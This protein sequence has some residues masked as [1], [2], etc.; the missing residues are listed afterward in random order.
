MKKPLVKN[1]ETAIMKKLTKYTLAYPLALAFVSS[2]SLNIQAGSIE[3][4][5]DDKCTD[6]HEK[7]GNSKN[8]H[9]PSIA[10]ISST[11]FIEAMQSYGKDQRPAFKLK[12]EKITMKDVAKKLSKED[13]EKLADYFSKQKFAATKQDFDKALAKKGKKLHKKYCDKCHS[14]NATSSEDDAGILAGQPKAYIKY[15]LENYAN[16]KREMG[17]KMAKKFKKMNKKYGAEALEHL[18]NFYASHQ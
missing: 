14:E 11:Y 3:K 2:V 10:G 4:L 13:I 17:E 16:G 8:E 1:E 18:V 9:T 12:D 5:I 15:S 6:C 7:N